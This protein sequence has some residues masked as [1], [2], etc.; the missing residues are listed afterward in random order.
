MPCLC[1]AP[2]P[3]LCRA[4]AKPLPRAPLMPLPPASRA[5]R[6]CVVPARLLRVPRA[7]CTLPSARLRAPRARIMPRPSAQR[8]T[9]CSMG[10]S[11]FPIST[12]TFFFSLFFFHFQLLENYKKHIPIF[13]FLIFQNT[14]IIYK[15][16][17][18][19]LFFNFPPCKIQKYYF[20][21]L[22]TK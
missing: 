18:S 20:L 4:P 10:S 3:C 7:W 9:S 5:P 21:H 1:R 6:A 14:Q 15:N 8:P 22:I 11:P 13:F 19:L 2:V 17:F 16:L 12:P